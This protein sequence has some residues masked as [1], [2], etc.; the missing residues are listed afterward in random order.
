[1]RKEVLVSSVNPVKVRHHHDASAPRPPLLQR[2]SPD[3]WLV[4]DIVFAVAVFAVSLTVLLLGFHGHK[5][6]EGRSEAPTWLLAVFLAGS[7]LPIAVRRKRPLAVLGCVTVSLAAA[8]ALGQSFA[9]APMISLPMYTVAATRSRNESLVALAAVEL[10]LALSLGVALALRPT[11]GD[12]TFNILI[13]AAGWF[14]GDSVR[15]RRAF[16]RATVEQAE[17][18]RHQEVERARRA[19]VEERLQI[20]RELHDVVAHSLAVIAVQSGAGRHVLDTQ[21]EQARRALEAVE[22]TSRSA[23]DELRRVVGVLRTGEHGEPSLDP[24]P[25]IGDLPRL[26][27]QVRAAGVPVQ[28]ELRGTEVP[29]PRSLELSVYRIVQEAL[30]NVV[31]HAGPARAVVDVSFGPDAVVIDV[32]D[33]GGRSANGSTPSPPTAPPLP[34]GD[35][36][37]RGPS[38]AGSEPPHEHHGIAGMRERTAVFGGSLVAGPDAHGGFRVSA[39]LPLG[40]AAP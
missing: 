11:S 40:S 37:V 20:A 9:P 22:T 29:L 8:T 1:M 27:E 10:S 28:L 5:V 19:T 36:S 23:L 16:A 15:A 21:P 18:L 13:A 6:G 17:Q 32:V 25:G 35:A 2:V 38:P 39:R 7:S 34:P 33:D 14:A 12:V 26:V 3:E 24:T 4:V 30:T 31:K